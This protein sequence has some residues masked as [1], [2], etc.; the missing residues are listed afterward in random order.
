MADG[1]EDVEKCFDKLKALKNREDYDDNQYLIKAYADLLWKAG[2]EDEAKEK[3]RWLSD[4]SNDGLI[5]LD[6]SEKGR[7]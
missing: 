7:I 2:N 1:E 4:N 3:Y 6:I 5:L